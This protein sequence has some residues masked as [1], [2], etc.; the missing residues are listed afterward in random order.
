MAHTVVHG[1][2]TRLSTD[3]RHGRPRMARGKG[4]GD[5]P[6][7][8][9]MVARAASFRLSMDSPCRSSTDGPQVVHG[10]PNRSAYRRSS[11][12]PP[13]SKRTNT[14]GGPGKLHS[15]YSRCRWTR[16]CGP[17]IG[18]DVDYHV[19][20][21]TDLERFFPQICVSHVRR[22]FRRGSSSCCCRVCPTRTRMECVVRRLR[23]VSTGQYDS[24]G[25]DLGQSCRLGRCSTTGAHGP[26]R[27]DPF[28]DFTVVDPGQGC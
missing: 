20:T 25:A 1:W 6:W 18:K 15:C 14:A 16:C 17:C 10:W 19:G 9:N 2:P 12:E 23:H 4:G 22:G 26:D 7:Y 28:G 11:L 8:I 3:G 21:E 24:T 27:A 13:R 5:V